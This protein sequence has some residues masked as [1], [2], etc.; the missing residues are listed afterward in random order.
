MAPGVDEKG[1][2]RKGGELKNLDLWQALDGLLD[3]HHMTVTWI[4]GHADN[5]YNN[6]C[7]AIAVAEREKYAT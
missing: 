1:W 6:R 4:R 7:D 2:K 5:E 3:I